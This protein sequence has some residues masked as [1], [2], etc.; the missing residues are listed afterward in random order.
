[1]EQNQPTPRQ[2]LMVLRIIWGAM[3]MGLLVFLIV[4][5]TV[6]RNMPPLD[7]KTSQLFLYI[8]VAMLAALVPTAFVV[9]AAIYRKDTSDAGVA[10]AAYA[11]GNI[12]FWAMCEGVA[13]FGLVSG[14]LNG[15]RGPHLFV[16]AVAI[17]AI[18]VNFP[19]GGS[20][21]QD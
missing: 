19:T 16:A 12:V 21:R 20:M 15:G 2:R 17:A 6:G 3:L 10:P 18:V 14:M 9:R 8:A 11:T 7:P 13:F 1:M 4:V 5:L